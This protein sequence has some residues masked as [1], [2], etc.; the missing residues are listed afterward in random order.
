MTR[1]GITGM[2]GEGYAAAQFSRERERESELS[3]FVAQIVG[4]PLTS[5]PSTGSLS[6]L[7]SDI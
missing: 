6:P 1:A 4:I 7:V 2:D 5:T 3:F